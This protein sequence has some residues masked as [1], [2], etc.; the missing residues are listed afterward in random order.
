MKDCFVPNNTKPH[1]VKN[2][3]KDPL[4]KFHSKTC[5]DNR[6]MDFINQMILWLQINQ[7]Q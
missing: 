1:K 5:S 3:L 2:P 4:P 7:A 6:A